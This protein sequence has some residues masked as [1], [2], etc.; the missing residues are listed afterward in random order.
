MDKLISTFK[1]VIKDWDIGELF[2][3]VIFFPWSLLYIGLK[4]IQEWP[5]EE[6]YDD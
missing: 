1:V 2:L 4:I 6:Q 5:I 3:V